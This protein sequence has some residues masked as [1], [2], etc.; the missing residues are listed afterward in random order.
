[1][2]CIITISHSMFDIIVV[3]YPLIVNVVALLAYIVTIKAAQPLCQS[4]YPY[5]D[6]VRTSFCEHPVVFAR[7]T[8]L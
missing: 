1:M 8:T 6:Y 7:I 2:V 3:I 5:S 4:V